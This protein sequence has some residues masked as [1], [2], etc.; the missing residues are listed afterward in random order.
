MNVKMTFSIP[1]VTETP[2]GF[3]V[4]SSARSAMFIAT[5]TPDARPSS[6][7]A[8]W[9]G[10]LAVTHPGRLTAAL[11]AAI[12]VA[13]LIGARAQTPS[14]PHDPGTPALTNASAAN[15]TNHDE[16]LRRALHQAMDGNPKPT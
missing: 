8:A 16:I 9:F 15:A 6:V 13:H 12:V 4:L 7:G 10:T 3:G 1:A 14:A 11:A 2:Q 5:T